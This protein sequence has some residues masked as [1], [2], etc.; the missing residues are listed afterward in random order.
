[1]LACICT[2]VSA[3]IVEASMIVLI[4]EYILTASVFVLTCLDVI[5]RPPEAN[6]FE[7]LSNCD[8]YALRV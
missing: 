6:H 2:F 3:F 7:G 8:P 4:V 5:H 1:M